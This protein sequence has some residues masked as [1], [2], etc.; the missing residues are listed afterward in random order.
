MAD[1]KNRV[2]TTGGSETIGLISAEGTSYTPPSFLLP[3][4]ICQTL[5][6]MQPNQFYKAELCVNFITLI[7][8]AFKE[9]ELPINRNSQIYI[10]NTI[11]R[12]SNSLLIGTFQVPNRDTQSLPYG[13]IYIKNASTETGQEFG[14]QKYTL[15]T[16][17]II[18]NHVQILYS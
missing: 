11:I 17:L 13:N 8:L 12:Y 10:I 1:S 5:F 14:E 4:M 7:I 16:A 15:N 6:M 18:L 2:A 3:N 9:P